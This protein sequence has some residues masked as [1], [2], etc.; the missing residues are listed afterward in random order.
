VLGVL[1]GTGGR[2]AA[3]A[4]E[5]AVHLWSGPEPVTRDGVRGPAASSF[6]F[7]GREPLTVYG[8]RGA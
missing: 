5:V 2:R 6:A 3:A 7:R 4:G 1:L 8:G